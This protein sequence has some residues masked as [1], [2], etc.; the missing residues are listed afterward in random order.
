MRSEIVKGRC[1]GKFSKGADCFADMVLPIRGWKNA[2]LAIEVNG[3]DHTGA[4]AIKRGTKR[5][6]T[7]HRTF[8]VLVG[9]ASAGHTVWYESIDDLIIEKIKEEM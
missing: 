1:K 9:S 3:R 8:E 2:G 6:R 4:E 5:L 7:A